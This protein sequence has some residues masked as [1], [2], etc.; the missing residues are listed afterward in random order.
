MDKS[1]TELLIG[2]EGSEKLKKANIAIVGVGGVGG[3]VCHML[4]R[5]GIENL[6][7]V[8]FDIVSPSNCNRQVV[9]D[10][11][12][13]GQ[14]KVDVMKSQL[15]KINPQIKVVVWKEKICPENFEKILLKDFDYVIDCID[16]VKNKVDMIVFCKKHNIKI[17]SAMGAGNRWDIPKFYLTDIFKTHDDGLA[18]AIRKR[19]RAEGV[20]DLEVVTCDSKP[21]KCEGAVGSISYYPAMCGITISAV[22]I[23][24]LLKEEL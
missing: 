4:A 24:K 1:R 20:K 22:V 13:I 21:Q 18:K 6:T 2:K 8:D 10:S 16:D 11:Q 9:A 14:S 15:E 17:L 19:L 5:S 3:Y 7:I 23:N 12:T